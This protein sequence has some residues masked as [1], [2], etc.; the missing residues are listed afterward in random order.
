LRVIGDKMGHSTALRLAI[1]P[2]LFDTLRRR[3]DTEIKFVHIT[4]NPYVVI[5]SQARRLRQSVAS[6][7]DLFFSCA[8]GVRQIK[9][10]VPESQIHEMKHE[11]FVANP[12]GQLA[13]LCTFLNLEPSHDYLDACASMSMDRR[14]EVVKRFPGVLL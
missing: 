12:K 1:F 11:E 2:F 6:S 13:S 14:T 9:K 10:S 7:Y 4:R 8:E 3:L 5:G